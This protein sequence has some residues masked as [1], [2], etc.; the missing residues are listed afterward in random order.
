MTS[1]PTT[2]T[3]SDDADVLIVGAGPSG[4]LLA[5]LLGLYGVRV[6]VI[7]AGE[8]L[9]DYPRGVGMDDETLR[10]IQTA[11]LIDTV[12]PHT[13]P[14]QLVRWVNS[15]GRVFAEINPT[16]RPFGWPRR[17]GFVQPLVDRELLA[18]LG[19]FPHAEVRFGQEMTGF[20]Q[21]PDR[22]AVST[23]AAT[24]QTY[25]LAARFLVG[26]DGG[27]SITRKEMGVSF[28]GTS[29]STRW[30]VIDLRNDPLGSPNAY[31]GADKDRPYVS[32][33]IPHG[34]RRFEFMMRPDEP[35]Q[36]AEDPA[37]VQDMLAKFL[38]DPASA[39]IIRRRVYTHHSRIAGA[40]GQGRVFLAG[41]A[42]HLM[43]VWQGQGY[44]SGIRDAT[45]LA[46][47]LAC[48]TSGRCAPELLD[49]YDS[50]RR[51]HAAAMISLSTLS[52]RMISP[53][54][55]SLLLTRDVLFAAA[56][57]IPPVKQYLLQMRYKPMPK[58]RDGAVL[59][60]PTHRG[61]SSVGTLFPQPRVDTRTDT[62]VLLDDAIG[63]WFCL[64]FWNNDPRALLS[65]E[66]IATWTRLGGQLVTLRPV[67]QLF[68][69]GQ[70]HDDVLVVG[71]R[72]GSV[73]QFFDSHDE[74]VVLL[75]PDRVIAGLSVAAG[76]SSLVHR[77]AELIGQPSGPAQQAPARDRTDPAANHAPA[78]SHDDAHQPRQPKPS[79][80]G[81]RERS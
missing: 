59:P 73:K 46:W 8:D 75:R 26:C 14:Q 32:I 34:I 7:E 33:S 5:N 23:R 79:T 10:S 3:Q 12:L 61:Q 74:S 63:P 18:G 68:W 64:L 51:P 38:P 40:F 69:T 42:A 37:F 20:T 56:G 67:N 36:R 72:T 71:D 15:R 78:A 29:S 24:G 76:A 52:G 2:P 35:D 57:A 1:P 58:Y 77:Y 55:R 47:K 49:T 44:N 16:A 41:D 31:V 9:I 25:T 4:L 53:A 50:E 30:L 81:D 21:A 39:D 66:A 45:N 28:E 65:D 17:N 43:P 19:R 48:V 70:D 11:G 22:V 27:R 62:D 6:V 60:C 13:V 80:T 54:N